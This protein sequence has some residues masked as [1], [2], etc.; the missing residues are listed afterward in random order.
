MTDI[1]VHSTNNR[2]GWNK[3]LIPLAILALAVLVGFLAYTTLNGSPA[4]AA[5]ATISLNALE[6]QYGLRVN[7]VGVTAAGGLVDVRMKVLNA[8]KARAL[9]QERAQ[10]PVLAVAGSRTLLTAPAETQEQGLK[11]EDNGIL[12]FLFPNVGN[13]V[14]PGDRVNILFGEQRLESIVAK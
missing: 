12:Y 6:E 5:T 10:Y 11:L 3:Y 14:K 9:L 13:A 2:P 1:A 7:L 8:E 4:P